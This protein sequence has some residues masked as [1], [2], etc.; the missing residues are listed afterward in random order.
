MKIAVAYGGGLVYQHFGHTPQFK[1]YNTKEQEV[2][3]TEILDTQDS[4]HSAL[5]QML[6]GLQVDALIC[7]GIGGCARSALTEAG[8]QIYGGVSGDA[9]DAVGALLYG[10][11][12]FD[13][14]ARCSHHGGDHACG[15]CSK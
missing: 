1:I 6:A 3:R 13:P 4:G 9:D 11:L 12:A 5:A 14:Q 15:G 8:I 2:V 10:E 7:G